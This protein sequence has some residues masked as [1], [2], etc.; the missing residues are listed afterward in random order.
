[1]RAPA[2]CY[3]TVAPFGA[4]YEP[5]RRRASVLQR[6]AAKRR[7]AVAEYRAGVDEIGIVDDAFRERGLRFGDERIDEP[8]P[9]SGGRRWRRLLRAACRSTHA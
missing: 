6:A 4:V 2:E 3:T 1:M 5:C 7:E 9:E 8:L